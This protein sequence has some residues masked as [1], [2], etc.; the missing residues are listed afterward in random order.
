MLTIAIRVRKMRKRKMKNRE[1]GGDYFL[2]TVTV[3]GMLVRRANVWWAAAGGRV[4]LQRAAAV[5]VQRLKNLGHGITAVTRHEAAS[6]QPIRICQSIVICVTASFRSINSTSHIRVFLR[7]IFSSSKF[8]HVTPL[9]R[10]LHWL[11]APE[12]IEFKYAVLVS[13]QV[14]PQVCTCIPY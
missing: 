14:S 11:K 8:Q 2:K 12:R 10:Q 6:Y 5:H 7:L 9:L 3:S 13:L 4:E 1:T